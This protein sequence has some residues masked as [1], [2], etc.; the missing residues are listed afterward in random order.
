MYL[1]Y[2]S[3]NC[4]SV[5]YKYSHEQTGYYHVIRYCTCIMPLATASSV[6]DE[7]SHCLVFCIFRVRYL[8]PQKDFYRIAQY[9][10]TSTI[11]C[12]S[13]CY[14]LWYDM[15]FSRLVKLIAYWDTLFKM[16]LCLL[17]L[18]LIQKIGTEVRTSNPTCSAF[19]ITIVTKT[20]QLAWN[21]DPQCAWKPLLT[22]FAHSFRW[23]CMGTK[24]TPGIKLFHCLKNATSTWY[25]RL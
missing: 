8:Q 11:P 20:T 2:A 12:Y 18:E 1:H 15:I 13:S 25:C 24:Y 5:L 21:T 22:S 6:L 14:P 23:Q 10:N 3:R 4:H 7:D 17:C 9:K 19:Y 16:N